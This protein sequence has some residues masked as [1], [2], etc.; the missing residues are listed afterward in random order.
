MRLEDQTALFIGAARGIGRVARTPDPAGMAIFPARSEAD[1]I[2]A[3]TDG[4][5]GRNWIA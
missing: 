3:R 1:Y 2:V 4:A 5:D